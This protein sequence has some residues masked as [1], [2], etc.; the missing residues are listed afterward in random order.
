MGMPR[1][2]SSV[3]ILK[4]VVPRVELLPHPPEGLL[5][6]TASSAGNRTAHR[7][8]N[9]K[10]SETEEMESKKKE[11]PSLKYDFL[12]IYKSQQGVNKG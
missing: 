11:M 12:N 4:K 10:E 8:V 3:P 5:P 7:G 9:G 2:L 6:A 1:R